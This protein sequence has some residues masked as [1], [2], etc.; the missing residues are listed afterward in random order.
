MGTPATPERESQQSCASTPQLLMTSKQ[1]ADGIMQ[2]K[3]GAVE[4]QNPPTE[5]KGLKASCE[6]LQLEGKILN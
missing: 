3:Q 5:P 4:A 6:N 2:G 1:P